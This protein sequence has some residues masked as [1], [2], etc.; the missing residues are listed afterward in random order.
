MHSLTEQTALANSNLIRFLESI[1]EEMSSTCKRVRH[2]IGDAH[3]LSDGHQHE[4][5]LRSAIKKFVGSRFT[6][7]RGFVLTMLD[8]TSCSK[9]Q[10]ILVVDTLDE[11]PIFHEFGL[12]ITRVERVKAAI[13]VKAT[14]T[15]NS[16]RDSLVGL[17]T[18]PTSSH[19]KLDIWRAAFF[20]DAGSVNNK[21]GE[22][23]KRWL[24]DF[25]TE[26]LPMC[27]AVVCNALFALQRGYE[28]DQIVGNW[29]NSL[30]SVVFLGML[31]ERLGMHSGV[32]QGDLA[33]AVDQF[34]FESIWP[35]GIKLESPG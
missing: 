32:P 14:L 31:G 11:K 29:C 30:T 16:L 9:E 3:W 6:V 25:S 7:D 13:S 21:D 34:T 5:V 33:N 26:G 35:A 27:D 2:L 15:K 28:Q 23:L 22:K 4:A 12:A 24:E 8:E 18:V 20:F 17:A 19:Q 10:D 1:E